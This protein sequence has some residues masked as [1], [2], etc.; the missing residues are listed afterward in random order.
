MAS[1]EGQG[2]GG[3]PRKRDEGALGWLAGLIVLPLMLLCCAGPFVAAAIASLGLGAWLAAHGL[4]VGALAV[5]VVGV[6]A[7]WWA[8]HRRRQAAAC[9]QPA[10]PTLAELD[11][12]D[13]R[14][15]ALG[16]TETTRL[17]SGAR[18]R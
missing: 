6:G 14:T 2:D 16:Q 11:T 5:V 13:Y 12:D 3:T 10:S 1:I 15:S 17:P 4:L 8:L 18:H 9:C 7:G